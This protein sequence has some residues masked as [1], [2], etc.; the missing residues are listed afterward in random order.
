M[1]AVGACWRSD[2][3]LRRLSA[4]LRPSEQRNVAREANHANPGLGAEQAQDDLHVL[5]A[6]RL[7]SL[8]ASLAVHA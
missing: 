3:I 5:K 1:Y 2:E 6:L 4:C 8:Y 7:G